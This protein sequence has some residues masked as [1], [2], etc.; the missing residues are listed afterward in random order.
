MHRFI[1]EIEFERITSLDL[2]CRSLTFDR[3]NAE[4]LYLNSLYTVVV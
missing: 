4:V 3:N 1:I 2:S